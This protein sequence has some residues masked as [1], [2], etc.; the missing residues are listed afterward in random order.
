M[1]QNFLY[2]GVVKSQD[3]NMQWSAGDC[4]P[5]NRA[6]KTIF[7]KNLIFEAK[8]FQF[9]LDLADCYWFNQ[10]LIAIIGKLTLLD[11]HFKKVLGVH[12]FSRNIFDFCKIGH[13]AENH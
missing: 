11:V 1:S 4:L 7:S 5:D 10:F 12:R 13:Q 8:I 2:Q 3:Y 6:K 9:F